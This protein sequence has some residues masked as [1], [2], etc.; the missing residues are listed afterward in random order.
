[1]IRKV[2]EI[3]DV[4][5]FV[6][7][8]KTKIKMDSE[9]RGSIIRELREM[10]KK[11]QVFFE[12]NYKGQHKVRIFNKY[13][14]KYRISWRCTISVNVKLWDYIKN[15]SKD[16]FDGTAKISFSI[17]SLLKIFNIKDTEE[18]RIRMEKDIEEICSHTDL[19]VGDY[20]RSFV[21]LVDSYSKEINGENFTIYLP[22]DRQ[23]MI[24][25]S[26]KN[27]IIE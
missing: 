14:V 7:Y 2:I 23:R 6:V 4:D 27:K 26:K 22:W 11:G 21:R 16:K 18:N 1:M 9:S 5:E 24:N 19:I 3:T 8:L 17:T 25:F 12:E 10:K 15:N 20:Q 13:N